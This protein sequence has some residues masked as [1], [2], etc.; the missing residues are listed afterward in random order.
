MVIKIERVNA[1]FDWRQKFV[2]AWEIPITNSGQQC[3]QVIWHCADEITSLE[4]AVNVGVCN[5]TMVCEFVLVG[6]HG[7]NSNICGVFRQGM[8][9]TREIEQA[10]MRSS[11]YFIEVLGGSRKVSIEIY[12]R[13]I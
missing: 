11:H 8:S 2:R 10:Q 1:S 4:T 7:C 9:L 3:I 13:G 6:G 12:S 5:R